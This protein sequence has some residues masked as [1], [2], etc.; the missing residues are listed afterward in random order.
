MTDL[1]KKKVILFFSFLD[2]QKGYYGC[3]RDYIKKLLINIKVCL[4]SLGGVDSYA[5]GE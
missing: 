4:K 1:Y 2:N 3:Y 5:L